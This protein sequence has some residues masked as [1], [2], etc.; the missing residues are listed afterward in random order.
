[1]NTP[2]ARAAKIMAGLSTA[3]VEHRLSK[4]VCDDYRTR[5]NAS[6]V[7]ARKRSPALGA[8]GLSEPCEAG[9][10]RVGLVAE[11]PINTE[12]HPIGGFFL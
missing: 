4:E 6:N 12:R 2:F 3:S 1:M 9:A 7:C 5:M 10:I 11:S 8:S